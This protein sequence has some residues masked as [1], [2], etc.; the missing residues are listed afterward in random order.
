MRR[1]KREKPSLWKKCFQFGHPK[2]YCRKTP[3]SS[4]GTA[5]LLQTSGT[6]QC[7]GEFCLC[8]EIPLDGKREV[9]EEYINEANVLV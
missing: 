6:H 9:C 7:R 3:V 8:W 4:V 5:N 2:K 1:I